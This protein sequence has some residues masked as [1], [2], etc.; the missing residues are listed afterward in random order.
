M[1]KVPITGGFQL[2]P[3][4]THI[5]RIYAASYDEEFGK[6]E[7]K[8][9]NADGIT[10]TER[11]SILRSDNTVNEGAMNAFSYFAKNAMNDFSL[12]ELDPVDLI[13]HYIEGEIEHS[14]FPSNR[15]PKKT[16]TFANLGDKRPADGFDKEPTER[17][18]TL[19]KAPKANAE[20]AKGLD[21]DKLLGE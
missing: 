5:F 10:H 16:V 8:M 1:A 20:P 9:V 18:L 12:E 14:R 4:G 13:D 15:D 17:A 7:V 3:E 21:I 6:I 2:I 11:F 19:G